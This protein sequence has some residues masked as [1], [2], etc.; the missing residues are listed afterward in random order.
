MKNNTKQIIYS[1]S[2]YDKKKE[3]NE[4]KLKRKEQN[5][6]YYNNRIT[7]IKVVKL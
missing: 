6:K 5:K 3:T 4:W 1:K 7:K 2:Y